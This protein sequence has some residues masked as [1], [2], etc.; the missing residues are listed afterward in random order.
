VAET[1]AE[2]A[3]GVA[4]GSDAAGK[5][6]NGGSEGA[7]RAVVVPVARKAGASL[8]RGAGERLAKRIE[9]DSQ[10]SDTKDAAPAAGSGGAADAADAAARWTQ[11]QLRQ[12]I[13]WLLIAGGVGLVPVAVA[14]SS[15]TKS[16]TLLYLVIGLAVAAVVLGFTVL[17]R[18]GRASDPEPQPDP[19]S[20]AE[21]PD[22]AG[23]E[24]IRDYA[25]R[26]SEGYADGRGERTWTVAA[27]PGFG[28]SSLLAAIDHRF[29][30][31]GA[32][33]AFI[34]V[35]SGLSDYRTCVR[36]V[37]LISC[38]LPVGDTRQRLDQTLLDANRAQESGQ[39]LTELLADLA[40]QVRSVIAAIPGEFVLLMDD[41]H[42][43]GGTAA[44]Q[45]LLGLGAEIAQPGH[46]LVVMA[47]RHTAGAAEFGLRLRLQPHN[48]EQV[49]AE[50]RDRV[51]RAAARP[52]GD[53]LNRVLA[54]SGGMPYAVDAA[55]RA[56]QSRGIGALGDHS[57]AGSEETI[58][59]RV[60]AETLR[61][62]D[63]DCEAICGPLREGRRLADWLSVLNRFGGKYLEDILQELLEEQEG[64]QREAA[65]R[66]VSWLRR[67]NHLVRTPD[68]DTYI[69]LR[70]LDFL[71][72]SHLADRLGADH[73]KL[74][75]MHSAVERK[76]WALVN[77][78]PED[79]PK[80][81][82]ES[83]QLRFESSDWHL[84]TIEWLNHA[85]Q[86]GPAAEL[87]VSRACVVLFFARYWWWDSY[88]RSAYCDE[89]LAEF[90]ARWPGAG[91]VGDLAV[92]R[93][94]YV[95][96]PIA[97][98]WSRLTADL[99]RWQQAETAMGRLFGRLGLPTDPELVPEDLGE[100][101]VFIGTM[102][103]DAMR[104][105]GLL[106]EG[107]VW[108]TR[109]EAVNRQEWITPWIKHCEAETLLEA[110]EVARARALAE[111]LEEAAIAFEDNDL[112][113]SA[114]VLLAD[115]LWQEKQ[116]AASVAAHTRSVLF[117]A[118][119]HLQ[120]EC[121]GFDRSSVPNPYSRQR[122]EDVA[123]RLT[124]RLTQVEA[125]LGK[126]ERRRLEAQISAFFAPYH[127]QVRA[128]RGKTAGLLPRPPEPA[129]VWVADSPYRQDIEWGILR[130]MRTQ[131]AQRLTEPLPPIE[132]G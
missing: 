100:A 56:V 117:A 40:E 11:E 115:I 50:I 7:V 48:E 57:S 127:A 95:S 31:G 54:Y 76:Y 84:L 27:P 60:A 77:T 72:E 30:E 101:Y 20:D 130:R 19:H 123:G 65:D 94:N 49:L 91:W 104:F 13:G 61:Q 70:L 89:L 32:L 18:A 93:A 12:A 112:R 73:A 29:H 110:G 82:L 90:K 83:L 81:H 14:Q 44:G 69:G 85:F 5:E 46:R 87:D 74:E 64:V 23:S 129:E 22:A 105:S 120:Q 68:N 6:S 124:R 106:D 51:G 21:L 113:L 39:G 97:P 34:T 28:K 26:I 119:Y 131:L 121:D 8:A 103:A 122:H 2:D 78:A 10:R 47:E 52:G 25:R 67:Q 80:V 96:G 16:V 109:L 58:L 38:D 107:L 36:L 24:R 42:N 92:F 62:M 55:C 35:P 125:V 1:E 99:T 43:I 88:V 45:W 4:Q 108:F 118:A 111:G 66:V 128:A 116:Y 132:A 71:Q 3:G 33:V 37:E 59:R 114:A 86:A 126:A 98:G 63:A 41:F 17:A 75:F 79:I 15:T 53:V 9:G 102:R